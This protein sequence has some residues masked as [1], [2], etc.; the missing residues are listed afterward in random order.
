[1]SIIKTQKEYIHST[2]Y[3]TNM[4]ILHAINEFFLDSRKEG[5]GVY[6]NAILLTRTQLADY[7]RHLPSGIRLESLY[8]LNI[9]LTD[10]I[11][12]PRLLKL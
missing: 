6:P 7:T 5:L 2:T 12:Q 9:I 8:G 3:L 10:Y 4:D 11:E 1:M